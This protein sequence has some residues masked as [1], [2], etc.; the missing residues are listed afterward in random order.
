MKNL[1]CA[2]AGCFFIVLSCIVSI[3]FLTY[4]VAGM[5][6]ES[7]PGSL[8]DEA[9]EWIIGD[10]KPVGSPSES[11]YY[12]AYAGQVIESGN[13]YYEPDLSLAGQPASFFCRV[14]VQ[15]GYLTDKYGTLRPGGYTHTG[16]DYGSCRKEGKNVRATM[17][18]VVTHA[19]WSYW[20]GWTV[21]VQNTDSEGRIYQT[22]YGH[23]CCGPSGVGTSFDEELSSLR[24]KV[25][26]PVNAGDVL[27]VTGQTGNSDGIH[28]HYEVRECFSDGH[29]VVQDPNLVLLPGQNQYCNW[30]EWIET[31][32]TCK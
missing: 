26:D 8:R 29:C 2:V 13:F 10:S 24:V 22:I 1:N 23:M 32:D 5:V 15:G 12:K 25:G 6:A 11:D 19:G 31:E 14:P 21:V 20:L 9:W 3:Y 18:G 30:Y 27:G 7:L 4:A 16:I 28:L 17:G